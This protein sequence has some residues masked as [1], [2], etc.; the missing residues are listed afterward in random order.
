MSSHAARIDA[1]LLNS[2]LSKAQ[3]A[4]ELLELFERHG[5]QMDGMHY[6]NLWNKLGRQ[7]RESTTRQQWV[8]QHDA[9]LSKLV[10]STSEHLP[11]CGAQPLANIAHGAA[12][13][14]LPGALSQQLFASGLV[15]AAQTS[16]GSWAPRHIANL[17]WA[18]AQA[19]LRDETSF[20]DA[21]A[22]AARPQLG[23][24]QP[25]ELGMLA[26]AYARAESRAFTRDLCRT[27]RQQP[28]SLGPQELASG[29]AGFAKP[30]ARLDYSTL[31]A[32]LEHL[33]AW[34]SPEHLGGRAWPLRPHRGVPGC[35]HQSA[36]RQ[37][38]LALRRTRRR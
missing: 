6:G 27:V 15:V 32:S 21:V 29:P 22:A 26:S 16:L 13:V 2:R 7:L 3:D 31:S 38:L 37:R 10:S 34:G 19:G 36:F 14:G 17:A 4:D 30:S 33:K 11:S 25:L 1:P 23:A 12:H 20:F 28:A 35:P 8:Q 24:F 5:W 18:C 9:A